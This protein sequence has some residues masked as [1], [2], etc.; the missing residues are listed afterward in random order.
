MYCMKKFVKG[1]LRKAA[2]NH[3]TLLFR[4]ILELG[5]GLG[6]TGL[7]TL[8]GSSLTSYIFTDCHPEV[9][10]LLVENINI[11][12]NSKEQVIFSAS[13]CIPCANSSKHDLKS[14]GIEFSH[15]LT[16]DSRGK[17]YSSQDPGTHYAMDHCTK[18]QFQD[19]HEN[20]ECSGTDSNIQDN[21]CSAG[22]GNRDSDIVSACKTCDQYR[23]EEM[24][25]AAKELEE[26]LCEDC[27]R[28]LLNKRTAVCNLNWED[29]EKVHLHRLGE[30]V[31]IVLAS[32]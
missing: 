16:P 27:G 15:S 14:E 29:V 5:S 28:V 11:N 25:I 24:L 6:L 19:H 32:G 20:M 1:D 10:K 21:D 9:L 3:L 31:D 30:N 7:L 23:K 4:R 2:L 17:F 13:E 22:D 12:L 8:M 18:R 26:C